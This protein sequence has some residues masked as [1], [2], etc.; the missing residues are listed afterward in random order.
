MNE[1]NI[2]AIS[3]TW[4]CEDCGPIDDMNYVISLNGFTKEYFYDGHFGNGNF[5]YDG[6]YNIDNILT[7]IT[8]FADA[9]G[10]AGFVI[11]NIH[12]EKNNLVFICNHKE[13]IINPNNQQS[14][15]EQFSTFIL[16]L[17]ITYSYDEEDNSKPY[18]EDD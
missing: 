15:S 4:Y 9:F 11:E 3:N 2:K 6:L 5:T 18:W 7:I 10:S 16:S 17:G 12:M 1:F 14:I 13:I 8:D